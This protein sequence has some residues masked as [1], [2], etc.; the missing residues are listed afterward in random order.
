MLVLFTYFSAGPVPWAVNS[1]IYPIEIRGLG[2]GVASAA[3]WIANGLIAQTFLT[4]MHKFGGS[5]TF[6]LYS[7]ISIAGWIW[8]WIF[9]PE[10]QGLSLDEVQIMF[11]NL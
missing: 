4:F 3:N 9:L 10:T 2:T 8:S 6:W 11:E 7:I 5:R 1:E